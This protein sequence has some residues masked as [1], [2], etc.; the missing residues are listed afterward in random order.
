M[1]VETEITNATVIAGNDV[2]AA[3]DIVGG[4]VTAAGSVS[5]H[6]A[7]SP[8]GTPTV[9]ELATDESLRR[10]AVGLSPAPAAAE[11]QAPTRAPPPAPPATRT[12]RPALRA[13]GFREVN[14]IRMGGLSSEYTAVK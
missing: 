10:V 4:R 6:S 12:A 13:A 5:C 2:R 11:A 3:G 1:A 8:A 9:I 14:R 7:G